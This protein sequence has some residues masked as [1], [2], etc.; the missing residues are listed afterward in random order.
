[1]VRAL[2]DSSNATAIAGDRPF[3]GEI[4]QAMIGKRAGG[5]VDPASNRRIDRPGS[6]DIP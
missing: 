5:Q 4:M 6:K 2:G 3:V 1:M